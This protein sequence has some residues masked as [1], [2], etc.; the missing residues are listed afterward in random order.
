MPSGGLITWIFA[1]YDLL[2]ADYL[3]DVQVFYI[4]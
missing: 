4:T 1:L 3:A 2:F